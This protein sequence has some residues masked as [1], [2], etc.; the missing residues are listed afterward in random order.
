MARKTKTKPEPDTYSP[1][2]V[3]ALLDGMDSGHPAFR[4]GLKF[5]NAWQIEIVQAVAG[6]EIYC[7]C[8]FDVYCDATL[9]DVGRPCHCG[10]V[11]LP[12]AKIEKAWRARVGL[13]PRARTVQTAG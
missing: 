6:A 13:P 7:N 10:G 2:A 9:D 11:L 3:A 5:G 1:A 12:G 8:C 4:G